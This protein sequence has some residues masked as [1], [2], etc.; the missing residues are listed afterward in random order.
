MKGRPS[1]REARTWS[2]R[3]VH[4]MAREPYSCTDLALTLQERGISDDEIVR[5][6]ILDSDGSH[7]HIGQP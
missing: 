4:N 2:V 1:E 7:L 6:H 3:P 5:R